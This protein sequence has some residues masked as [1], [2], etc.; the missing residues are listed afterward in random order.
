MSL[1]RRLRFRA[2][3]MKVGVDGMVGVARD[4][5]TSYGYTLAGRKTAPAT[6][7]D[8]FSAQTM[9]DP[10]PGYRTLLTG[11]DVPNVWYNRKRGIW[12]I[13]GYDDL[14][15]ALRDNDVRYLVDPRIVDGTSWITG[16]D[17]LGQH[18]VG[19]VA[20]R[21]F[22]ADGTIE[23]AEVR[24]G[25]PSPDGAGPLVSARGIEVGHIF[26]FGTKYSEPMKAVVASGDGKDVPVHMGSYGIGPSRLV[27]AIIEASHDDAGIIWPDA[28][29]PYKVAILNLKQGD[30]ATDGACD[31]LYRDLGAKGIDVLY[32]DR[33]ERAGGKFATADLIGIPWQVMVG[34]RGLAEGKVEVKNRATGT[35]ELM[36]Q[37]AALDL[38]GR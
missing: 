37:A 24:D 35:K 23:A 20:G 38:L 32:D 13:A 31:Q 21:D 14:R 30:A 4:K 17:K 9:H 29:A 6:D 22:T 15:K 16:A 36:S 8:P 19:L 10:Y 3:L 28:V 7:F 18:V 12:I 25:D 33:D 1:A 11:P 26:Y 2:S 34:P 27:A 5:A